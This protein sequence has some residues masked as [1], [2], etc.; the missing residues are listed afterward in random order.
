MESVYVDRVIYTCIPLGKIHLSHA[1]YHRVMIRV[2]AVLLILGTGFDLYALD[3]K[4]SQAGSRALYSAF[5]N[6]R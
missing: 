4:Y 6:S 2:V 1:P 3:G 5:Q